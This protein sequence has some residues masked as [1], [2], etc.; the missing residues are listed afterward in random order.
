MV[1]S[2]GK[3]MNG[4]DC[5][6]F[7]LLGSIMMLSSA[8]SSGTNPLLRTAGQ[9]DPEAIATDP[10][11]L[12]PLVRA[13]MD[14]SPSGVVRIDPRLLAPDPNIG[15]ARAEDMAALPEGGLEQRVQILEELGCSGPMRFGKAGVT[16]T[17]RCIATT[18]SRRR[19]NAR[20][21]TATTA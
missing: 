18:R 19:R 2:G 7:A 14:E 17:S 8:C 1:L 3:V 15:E 9:P 10:S 20:N 21:R 6:A 13:I 16:G 12:A 5:T 11:I 4:I